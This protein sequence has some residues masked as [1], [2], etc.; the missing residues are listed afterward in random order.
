MLHVWVFLMLEI[1]RWL[2][3]RS[4]Q[5]KEPT[6]VN[7]MCQSIDQFGRA[8]TV[9]ADELTLFGIPEFSY[10]EGENL[11]SPNPELYG[12]CYVEQ[13]PHCGRSC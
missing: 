7:N 2:Q 8:R 9:I 1:A 3:L 12:Y 6:V 4:Y 10:K 13:F 11:V 5:Q